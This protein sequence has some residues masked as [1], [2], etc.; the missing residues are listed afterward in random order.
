MRQIWIT[1]TGGPEVLQLREAADPAPGA[2]EVRIR[3]RAIGV[4]FADTMARVGLYP[5]APQFPFVPGY[6]VAGVI[7]AAGE[8]VEMNRVGEKVV[9]L[10]RFGGYSDCVCALSA[11]AARLPENLSFSEGASI[12]VV[13]LTAWHMLVNLGN[14]RRGQRV[15]VQAAAGGVGT[16]AL[17][18][19]KRIG[20]EVYGT[21]SPGKHARLKEMGLDHPIDYRSQ[22]FE[23]EVMRLTGGKG[24]HIALDA[25][26]GRSFKKS[27][28]TLTTGGRLM[29]FGASAASPGLGRNLFAAL[30]TVLGM[31]I[32]FPVSLMSENRG[33]LGINLGRMWGE[34]ELLS[35]YLVEILRGM[36]DG[37]FKPVVDCEIPFAEPGR[38]HARLSSRESFGKGVLVV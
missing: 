26:G 7:D 9:A 34:A 6:E 19:C 10:T 36:E 30:G 13:W 27:F 4:N 18:I 35:G 33:V 28:R 14:L 8:G 37:T 20:A 23:A 22:D 29:M 3:V 21:A 2:G 12:P 15:L 32:F 1:R 16:A 25:V 24:V 31:P 38:A 17:Q 11:A 5:D